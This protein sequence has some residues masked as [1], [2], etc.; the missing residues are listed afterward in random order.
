[1]GVGDH[2]RAPSAIEGNPEVAKSENHEGKA[3]AEAAQ[4]QFGY[5]V[6]VSNRAQVGSYCSQARCGDLGVF[7]TG[8]QHIDDSDV[9]NSD[10]INDQ[11]VGMYHRLTGAA[12]TTRTIEIGVLG[13]RFGGFFNGSL[14]GFSRVMIAVAQVVENGP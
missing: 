14:E 5:R 6:G 7:L 3:H 13:K 11:V 12:D 8:V 9:I 1:M 4:H 10:T 2:G